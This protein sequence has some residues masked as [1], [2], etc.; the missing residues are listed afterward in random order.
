MTHSNIDTTLSLSLSLSHGEGGMI[1]LFYPQMKLHSPVLGLKHSRRCVILP[2][3][4]YSSVIARSFRDRRVTFD[5]LHGRFNPRQAVI[6]LHVCLKEF[7]F[8]CLSFFQSQLP[9][10]SQPDFLY[11]LLTLQV[12]PVICCTSLSYI[13][14]FGDLSRQ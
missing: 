8:L 13:S 10:L 6:R 9:A 2:W 11:L 5:H 4:D 3:V 14:T 7:D 12:K 1:C